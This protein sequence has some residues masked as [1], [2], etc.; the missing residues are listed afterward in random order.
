VTTPAVTRPRG[1]TASKA[2]T[3]ERFASPRV[4]AAV[5]AAGRRPSRRATIEL[6]SIHDM[7]RTAAAL[8]TE[9]TE[10]RRDLAERHAAYRVLAVASVVM[11]VFFLLSSVALG[12][13][14]QAVMAYLP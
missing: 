5:A 8:T 1:T 11:I 7:L 13:A 10:R 3:R 14:I 6:T 4:A 9:E 2:P 12:E